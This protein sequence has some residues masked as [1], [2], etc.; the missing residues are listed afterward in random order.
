MI[1]EPAYFGS[2]L[3][4]RGAKTVLMNSRVA[5]IGAA[6]LKL[7]THWANEFGISV[8]GGGTGPVIPTSGQIFPSGR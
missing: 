1:Y 2:P 5:Q 3:V 4:A 6:K 7:R 8:P